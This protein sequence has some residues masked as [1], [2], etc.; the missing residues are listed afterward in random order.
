MSISWD[1]TRFWLSQHWIRFQSLLS[2]CRRQWWSRCLSHSSTAEERCAFA[3]RQCGTWSEHGQTDLDA[4]TY[5]CEQAE[6][7]LGKHRPSSTQFTP[8]TLISSRKRRMSHRSTLKT[9]IKYVIYLNKQSNSTRNWNTKKKG[10]WT[11]FAAVVR[12]YH[13]V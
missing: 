12:N 11:S 6:K 4:Q 2:W 1:R 9:L 13:F 5:Q 7:D 10:Q 3:L 8:H